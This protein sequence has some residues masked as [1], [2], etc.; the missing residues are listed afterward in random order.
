MR[1][2]KVSGFFLLCVHQRNEEIPV[3]P[4]KKRKEKKKRTANR[5]HTQK[6]EHALE[7][8]HFRW[9]TV[10]TAVF[11]FLL[12]WKFIERLILNEKKRVF[13]L[14]ISEFTSA[15]TRTGRDLRG[16]KKFRL[17]K[18]SREKE[19][20]KKRRKKCE[21]NPEAPFTVFSCSFFFISLRVEK[22][23]CNE[24][25]KKGN[26]NSTTA[27]HRNGAMRSAW[28]WLASRDQASIVRQ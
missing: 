27:R 21:E 14:E 24:K 16:K 26:N 15:T 5:T 12:I 10:K 2:R 28:S 4:Q 17:P 11:C 22:R 23:N 7:T 20:E 9:R 25:E 13:L 8:R 6:K 18:K 1:K 19:T 3:A